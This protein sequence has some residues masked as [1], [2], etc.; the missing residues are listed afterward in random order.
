MSFPGVDALC[1]PH[2]GGALTD[3][4]RRLSCEEGHAFDLARQG[5]APLVGAHSNL[6]TGDDAGQV[7]A[8]QDFL[9]GGLYEPFLEP[10]RA[11][12]AVDAPGVALDIGCGTG[13]Y[14]ADVLHRTGRT[15][16]GLD[17]SKYALRRAAKAHPALGAVLADAWRGLPLSDDS[18]A[19]V[20]N[21]FAPRNAVDIH[22]VLHPEGVLVTVTPDPEHLEPL[23]K[24]VRML[25]PQER[26]EDKLIESLSSHFERSA[27]VPVHFETP[28]DRKTVHTI[29]AMGPTARHY[30]PEELRRAVDDT[31]PETID[32]TVS[33][34]VSTW[35]PASL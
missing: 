2:C 26:K 35:L 10:I 9:A 22:R 15:G 11:A 34:T 3:G 20:L 1:C 28:I 19:V 6:T 25:Q 29:L 14:L 7:Q 8:R 23:P 13:Y 4:E 32:L 18:A 31:V 21:V 30:G 27:R 12:A 33:V 16:V 24:F 17:S 5:Y